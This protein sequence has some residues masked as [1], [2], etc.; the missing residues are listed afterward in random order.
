MCP[1]QRTEPLM[2][3]LQERILGFHVRFIP[4]VPLGTCKSSPDLWASR[5]VSPK[6]S[7][8]PSHLTL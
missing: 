7:T 8:P 6:G 5:A 1:I 2:D 4:P 3:P